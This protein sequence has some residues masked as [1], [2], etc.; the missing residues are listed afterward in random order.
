LGIHKYETLLIFENRVGFKAGISNNEK[1]P[2]F[3]PFAF[4][5]QAQKTHSPFFAHFTYMVLNCIDQSTFVGSIKRNAS[6]G[7]FSS[8]VLNASFIKYG[9]CAIQ[10]IRE[11]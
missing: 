2:V 6:L 4:L 3:P 5:A 11:G 9:F 7:R 8:R 10:E 1:T